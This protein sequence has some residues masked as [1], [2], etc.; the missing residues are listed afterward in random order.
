MIRFEQGRWWLPDGEAHLQE[1][2]TTVGVKVNDRLAYQRHKYLKALSY[3]PENRRRF[4]LDIGAHVGLWSYQIIQDF[5]KLWAFEPMPQHRDCWHENMAG[6][7]HC[8]LL[9][10]AL[11]ETR[12]NVRI[13]SRTPGSSGDTGV[14]PK[15]ECS[16][17]RVSIDENE[18]EVVA[19]RPLDEFGF[20]EVDFI[21]IDCEGYELF[22]LRGAEETLLR[23]KPVLI[24]EQKPETGMEERYGVKVEDC[25]QFMSK[26]GAKKL[27][28]IQGDYIFGW[29]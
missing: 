23:N 29:V 16:S 20:S 10:Y 22:I 3:V 26:L 15:A 13:R 24:V 21:K 8:I 2:M 28:G 14:D 18:G 9:P 27:A 17:L 6:I 11:G 25:L 5:K 1:W 12:G 4:A 7:S 19:L